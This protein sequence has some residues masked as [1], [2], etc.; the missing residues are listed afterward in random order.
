MSHGAPGVQPRR[1]RGAEGD[2]AG[3]DVVVAALASPDFLGRAGSQDLPVGE[4]RESA[5]VLRPV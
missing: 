1:A 5:R 2:E 3:F 4:D